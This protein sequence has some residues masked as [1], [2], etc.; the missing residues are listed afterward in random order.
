MS[1]TGYTTLE[2]LEDRL[3]RAVEEGLIT[4]EEARDEY[5][6]AYSDKFDLDLFLEC[7]KDYGAEIR[8]CEPG[9]GGLFVNGKKI[10]GKELFGG[11]TCETCVHYPPSSCDEK[12][13]CVCDPDEPYLNCYQKREDEMEIDY[14]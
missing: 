2:D 9:Q 5:L 6:T 10:T 12:P 3:D 1:G 14:E 4:E 8:P 7:A 11:W 13:C